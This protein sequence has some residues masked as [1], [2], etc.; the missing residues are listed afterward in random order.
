[1]SKEE[2]AL[3]HTDGARVLFSAFLVVLASLSGKLGE[4]SR[5]AAVLLLV[6][7]PLELWKPQGNDPFTGQWWLL[8]T[9][10]AVLL[11]FGMLLELIAIAL[12]RVKK[13][14]EGHNGTNS[15]S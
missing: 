12:L 6:F 15:G 10:T 8:L 7:V 9:G 2:V 14:M 4:F 11:A 5:E 3:W 1:M 13:N